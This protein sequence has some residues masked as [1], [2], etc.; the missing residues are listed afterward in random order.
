MGKDKRDLLV[1]GYGLGTIAFVFAVVGVLKHGV[2]LSQMVLIFCG[3]VFVLVAAIDWTA[4]R[5]GYCIW[6]RVAHIVG[7]IVTFMILGAVFVVVFCP[8]GIFLRMIGKD[9]LNRRISRTLKT[10][11]LPRPKSVENKER[12]YQQF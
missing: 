1:F 12:Y 2:N 4:L 9:F 11:W 10:Y 3:G 5:L 8:I 6:M 7:S